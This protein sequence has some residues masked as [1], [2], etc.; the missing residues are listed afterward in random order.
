MN[1]TRPF[2]RY[3]GGKWRL[4]PWIISHFPAHRIYTEAY[5]GAGSVLLRKARAYSEVYNDLDGQIV[6]LFRVLR[7]PM[8]ARELV[9]QVTLTPYARAEFD[10]SYLLAEDPI[11]QARRTLFRSMA[12][13]ST[14]GATGRWKTGFR[15]NVTRTGTTP[16]ADWRTFPAALE[17]I[18]ERLRGVVIEHDDALAVIAR[19]DGPETLHY[20]D[21]PYPHSTR[22]VRWAGEAYAHEMS[23]DQHRELAALLHQ[24]KGA[25]VLSGYACELYDQELYPDWQRVEH[26]A[27]ADGAKDRIEVLWLSRPAIP[28]LFDE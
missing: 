2:L 14:T 5:G 15:A 7:D 23:D 4:A 8:Q 18:I 10:A 24:V 3:H 9:R 26:P 28:T 22:Y 6:N 12:G 21:P 25:V 16:A 17:Q 19:Y 11:E 27:H 1:P 20:V 13:F